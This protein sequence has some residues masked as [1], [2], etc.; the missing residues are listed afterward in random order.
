MKKYIPLVSIAV[1]LL[2]NGCKKS[3]E[4]FSSTTLQDYS[5][6]T[7]GKYITYQLDS[8]IYLS[9]GTRDTTISYEVKFENDADITDNLGRPASRI[10]RY[11]RKTAANPWVPD[12]TFMTVN[13]TTSLEFMENNLRYVKLK[14]PVKDGTTWKGNSYID[15]YSLNSELKYLDDWD[16]IY[17]NVGSPATVGTFSLE[18]T[19]TVNQRDE[20]IGDPLDPASYSEV[21]IGTEKYA[22]GIGLVYRRFFH[23][24]YQPGSPAGYFADGSYGVTLTMID[25]N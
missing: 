19:L 17:E 8:L 3:T 12:A 15:T 18:N 5:P 11:I 16:Y 6:L 14:L 22:L 21:N 20:V 13:A 24:E 4:T 1:L 9:F 10:I 23:S 2:F 7:V 25:H